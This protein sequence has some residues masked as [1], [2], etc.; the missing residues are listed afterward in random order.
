MT[1]R[2]LSSPNSLERSHQAP[3]SKYRAPDFFSASTAF[4]TAPERCSES[5]WKKT[6]KSVPKSCRACLISSNIR[7][8]PIRRNTSALSSADSALG[9]CLITSA[10][11]SVM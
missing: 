3:F 6:S 2:S 8:T 4:S 11:M 7:L 5:S 10:A 9:S 1:T